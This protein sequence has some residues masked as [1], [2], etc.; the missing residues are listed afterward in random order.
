MVARQYLGLEDGIL[1]HEPL[2]DPDEHWEPYDG[3][4]VAKMMKCLVY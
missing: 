1:F 2:P 4:T 3:L